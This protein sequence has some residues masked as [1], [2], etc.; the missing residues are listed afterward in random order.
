[1]NKHV[2]KFFFDIF[3]GVKSVIRKKLQ[4]KPVSLLYNVFANL[5]NVFKSIFSSLNNS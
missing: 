3:F 5:S 4:F 1:M 2:F